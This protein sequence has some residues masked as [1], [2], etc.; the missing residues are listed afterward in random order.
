MPIRCTCSETDLDCKKAQN[1]WTFIAFVSVQLELVRNLMSLVEAAFLQ[2][3][4]HKERSHSC[5]WEAGIFNMGMSHG[6]ISFLPL[7]SAFHSR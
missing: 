3:R 7:I 1:N 5:P 2:F 6:G 4:F